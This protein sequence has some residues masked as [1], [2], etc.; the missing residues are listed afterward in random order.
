MQALACM[1]AVPRTS[2][3]EA[4]GERT[5]FSQFSRPGSFSSAHTVMRAAFSARAGFSLSAILLA[6]V[7][8]LGSATG[9]QSYS[10]RFTYL[11]PETGLTNH[12]VHVSYRSFL[13]WGEAA[14]LRTETQTQEFI[15]TVNADGLKVGA[16]KEVI[17]AISEGVTSAVLKAINPL[18]P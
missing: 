11:Q 13:M 4:P 17:N 3:T 1:T 2:Q 18:A 7:L 9:C 12:V 16:E 10:E 14:R 5:R 15:R 8:V 6:L